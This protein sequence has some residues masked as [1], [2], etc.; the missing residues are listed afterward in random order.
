MLTPTYKI[1][2][3]QSFEE[4]ET[5]AVLR[6]LKDSHRY[7]AELKGRSGQIPNQGILIDTLS[8]QEAKA[9]SEIE[10]IVTT[11]D[12]LFI[13]GT[14]RPIFMSANSK[15]VAKYADALKFGFDKLNTSQGLITNNTLIG[16]FQILKETDATFRV[17]PGTAL[18]NETDG[19]VVY[20]PPQNAVEISNHM[21]SLES[22]VNEPDSSALDPLV[23]MAIIHHQFES[24]HPFSDGNGRIGRILNVLYLTQ[25]GLLET[26]VLYLSRFIT[27]NKDQYYQLLQETRDT[28]E[29][30]PWILFMLRAVKETSEQTIWLIGEIK[31]L[32]AT[33]KRRLRENHSTLYS[34]DLINNLFRHPYTRIEYIVDE[35]GVGRQTA[36]R[37]LDELANAGLLE[38][39][40]HGKNNYYV[41]SPL[42][43]LLKKGFGN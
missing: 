13:A 5:T 22:F 34:Q 29:W 17:T 31:E 10:N 20:V 12:E 4:V 38:K 9:S 8:L 23:K 18:K 3:L 7:L 24:I 1:P 21:R 28:N 25:Q 11:Q 33:T 30:E 2:S 26:P 36:A 6:A 37:Y 27:Q 19:N 16:M 43:N 14:S 32:M 40:R 15:E 41:N 35:V 42:V 39:L